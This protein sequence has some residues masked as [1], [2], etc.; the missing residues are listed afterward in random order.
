M[1][2]VGDFEIIKTAL[3]AGD[4]KDAMWK[5]KAARSRA[6]SASQLTRKEKYASYVHIMDTLSGVLTG[7][8]TIPELRAVMK[9]EHLVEFMPGVDAERFTDTFLFY[10]EYAMDRYNVNF[11]EYDE[12]RCADA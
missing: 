11:P 10:L 5:I 7:K 4:I 9:A 6:E 3:L 1:N 12:K 8:K 2:V